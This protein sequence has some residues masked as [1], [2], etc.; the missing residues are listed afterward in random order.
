MCLIIWDYGTSAV[1]IGNLPDRI[2]VHKKPAN[3]VAFEVWSGQVKVG[4][5]GQVLDNA[6]Y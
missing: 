5:M 4:M 3:C 6:F 1:V 2:H